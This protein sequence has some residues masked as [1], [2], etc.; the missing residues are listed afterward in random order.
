MSA[1]YFHDDRNMTELT[2]ENLY[3]TGR[4]LIRDCENCTLSYNPEFI[5]QGDVINGL[6]QPDMVLIGEGSKEAGDM[7]ERMYRDFVENS[8][9]VKHVSVS[10][11]VSMSVS[12]SMRVSVSVS[13]SLILSVSV[14]VCVSVRVCVGVGVGGGG[15][16]E[17]VDILE[18]MYCD[19]C[20]AASVL[21]C[22][23]VCSSVLR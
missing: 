10:E 3:Q 23:A 7:L 17:T 12:V 1:C 21:Q 13:V 22:V 18:I 15:F 5:A 19:L 6:L 11:S 8:P 4:F 14:S 16:E 20:V 9:Q 2:F